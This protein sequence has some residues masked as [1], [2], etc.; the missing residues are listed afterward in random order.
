MIDQWAMIEGAINPE[1]RDERAVSVMLLW[2]YVLT[3]P[4]AAC[5][6]GLKVAEKFGIWPGATIA[7]DVLENAITLLILVAGLPISV[8][9]FAA[10][11]LM[12]RRWREAA[13]FPV[14]WDNSS[15][16]HPCR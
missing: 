12:R 9:A 5:F 11:I 16:W 8:L 10:A 14:P 13:S 1:N 6:F 7:N 15:H 4:P 3:G 2:V